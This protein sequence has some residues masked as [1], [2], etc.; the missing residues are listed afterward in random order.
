[1]SGSADELW[2]DLPLDATREEIIQR[3]RDLRA[4]HDESVRKIKEL[5]GALAAWIEKA[6]AEGYAESAA[7][8]IAE[9]R[10]NLA[11]L[12]VAIAS[13]GE[14]NELGR[15]IAGEKGYDI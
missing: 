2:P 8:T 5:E 13:L 3:G 7:T 6:E 9:A 12:R 14:R 15:E 1:M 10:E 11:G 4:V